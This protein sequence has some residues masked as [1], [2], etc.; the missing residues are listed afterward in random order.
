MELLFATTNKGKISEI[1]EII[2]LKG[3]TNITI[4]GIENSITEPDENGTTYQ[5]NAE[6]KFLH[7]QNH[8]KT[9]GKILFSED[10]GLEIPALE[11]G[12]VGV[13]SAP[14]MK[15]F[16]TKMECFLKIKE[17]LTLSWREA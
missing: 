9:N 13:N 16:Q 2:T 10:S 12:V 17:M 5:E 15:Q 3:Y 4:A 1:A 8:I 14:F 7:Y 11:N 6:I